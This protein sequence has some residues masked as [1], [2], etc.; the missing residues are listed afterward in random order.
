MMS[1]V[2]R[3]P[4]WPSAARTRA[5]FSSECL[6]TASEVAEPGPVSCCEWS[7]SLS[8]NTEKAGTSFSHNGPVSARLVQRS[9][10][11]QIGTCGKTRITIF[12]GYFGIKR[13]EASVVK[14]NDLLNGEHPP[15]QVKRSVG[16]LFHNFKVAISVRIVLVGLDC[17]EYNFCDCHFHIS[18]SVVGRGLRP[19]FDQPHGSDSM[20]LVL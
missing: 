13:K 5:R 19:G 7:G 18:I 15:V 3:R 16:S 11:H 8:H 1:V 2:S 14:L 17:V 4:F 12:I 10:L 6:I 20:R 9:G